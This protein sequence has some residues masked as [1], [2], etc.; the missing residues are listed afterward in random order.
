MTGS[1]G[2]NS[3]VTFSVSG[4]PP[5]LSAAFSPASATSRT[6]LS[7]SKSLFAL[8]AP[9]SYTVTVTGTS[10]SLSASTRLVVVLSLLL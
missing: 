6:T 1:N 9:G 2:F 8:V 5:G 3:P 4:L 7:L 10:G